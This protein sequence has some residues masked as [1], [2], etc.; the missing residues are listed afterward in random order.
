MLNIDPLSLIGAVVTNSKALLGDTDRILTFTNEAKK[1]H[2]LIQSVHEEVGSLRRTLDAINGNLVSSSLTHASE[3]NEESGDLWPTAYKSIRDCDLTLHELYDCGRG[4]K[5]Q[6]SDIGFGA[7][8][9]VALDRTER[10][11]QKLRSRVR[12]CI[13]SL[14]LVVQMISVY[15]CLYILFQSPAND[16][17]GI[18]ALCLQQ[19]QTVIWVRR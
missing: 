16:F 5:R 2:P 18:S 19:K 10:Q 13:T 6:S 17:L 8:M 1:V 15:L 11:L 14:Q 9:Q 4:F 3:K 7:A 12:T